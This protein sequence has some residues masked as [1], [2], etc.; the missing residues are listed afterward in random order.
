MIDIEENV[1]LEITGE[2]KIRLAEIEQ[3][4]RELADYAQ[5]MN[6]EEAYDADYYVE[7]EIEQKIKQA[8]EKGWNDALDKALGAIRR[9]DY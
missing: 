5:Q 9:L 8:Y 6:A 3:A 7:M 4:N 2:D 1:S